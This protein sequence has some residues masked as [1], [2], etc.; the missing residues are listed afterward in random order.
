MKIAVCA[1]PTFAQAC[2]WHLQQALPEAQVFWHS[3]GQ[4]N[5][6]N[7]MAAATARPEADMPSYEDL[8]QPKA[9]YALVWKPHHEFFQ[10]QPALRAIFN[11]G[12]GV[13][14]LLALPS[15]PR[16]I[17]LI[18][19]EDAG[20]AEP[21]A[22]YVLAAVLRI[23]R[24]FAAYARYQ[25]QSLWQPLTTPDKSDFPVGVLGLGAIGGSVAQALAQHGFPVR[26][27]S[28]NPRALAQ[29]TTYHGEQWSDF[30]GGLK[31]L[32]S[33]LPLTAD[34][35]GC[36]NRSSLSQL[37]HDGWLINVGRGAHVNEN[38]L[39]AL[40]DEGHLGGAILDVFETEPLPLTHPFWQHPRIEITP[41]VS[42]VTPVVQGVHQIASKI[43]AL[44]QGAAVTG[45]VDL[46]RGY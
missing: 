26:G 15:L 24:G 43:N 45:I 35:R 18:R 41:H 16:H 27:F 39:L 6:V 14:A 32:V 7:A 40:L 2:A 34:N 9:D 36:L 13:D 17:P 11:L 44:E 25:R 30:L 42:A 12:A 1:S 20:M 21:M 22:D 31:I 29:V 19:L 4:G 23:Y 3:S 10:Q 46:T 28:R 38:D 33:L 5:E 37:A 8:G